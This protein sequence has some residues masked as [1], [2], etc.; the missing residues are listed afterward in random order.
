MKTESNPKEC[1]HSMV[2]DLCG[3]CI[4]DGQIAALERKISILDRGL[5]AVKGG[6]DNPCFIVDRTLSE[7]AAIGC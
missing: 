1:P 5:R 7:A 2:V 3:L 4:R 6:E